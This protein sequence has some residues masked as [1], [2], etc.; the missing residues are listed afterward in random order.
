LHRTRGLR[1]GAA[2]CRFYG[3]LFDSVV[4]I[5]LQLRQFLAPLGS[6]GSARDLASGRPRQGGVLR[7]ISVR[8]RPGLHRVRLLLAATFRAYVRFSAAGRCR[9]TAAAGSPR[10]QQQR[11]CALSF[12]NSVCVLQLVRVFLV[13]L[14][15]SVVTSRSLSPCRG[16]DSFGRMWDLR[17][18]RCVMFM[19]G[20]MKSILCVDFS[21]NG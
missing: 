2:G 15:F 3:A 13:G 9:C 19:E 5:F 14:R 8:R 12:G 16:L 1:D 17:T 21:P 20:H 18:G 10:Q 4:A 7:R 11:L 6:R